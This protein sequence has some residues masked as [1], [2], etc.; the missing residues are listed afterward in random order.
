MNILYL[1]RRNLLT[2]LNKLDREDSSNGI[3]KGDTVHPKYPIT[4]PTMV[5]AIEDENYYI[6]RKPGDVSDA[7]CGAWCPGC[8]KCS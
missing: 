2:L 1:S 7:P 4:E 5:F 8:E 6:D 3:I